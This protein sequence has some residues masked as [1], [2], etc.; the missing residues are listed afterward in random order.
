VFY[1]LVFRPWFGHEEEGNA[2]FQ[3]LHVTGNRSDLARQAPPDMGYP[4]FDTRREFKDSLP[5]ARFEPL[6]SYTL[7]D[8]GTLRMMVRRAADGQL[9]HQTW[10]DQSPTHLDG[11]GGTE[12]LP[13]K[14]ESRGFQRGVGRRQVEQPRGPGWFQFQEPVCLAPVSPRSR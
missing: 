1:D 8:G 2:L 5:P 6:F 10:L 7:P 3:V 12:H 9:P 13:A 14:R 4:L 11:A